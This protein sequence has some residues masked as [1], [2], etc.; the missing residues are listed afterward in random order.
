MKLAM[1]LLSDHGVRFKNLTEMHRL[2]F[3]P[4]GCVLLI[5]AIV[6]GGIVASGYD[7]EPALRG[8]AW[9]YYLTSTSLLRDHDFDLANQLPDRLEDHSGEI[10]LDRNGHFVPKHNIVLAIVSLPLV[11]L[12][13]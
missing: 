5:L 9:Y 3:T 7:G 10:A 12:W 2:T 13:D 6:Y 4:A 8:D 1:T 11:A